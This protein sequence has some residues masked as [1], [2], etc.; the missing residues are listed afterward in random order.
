MAPWTAS[1]AS[2]PC[3]ATEWQV[4]VFWRRAHSRFRPFTL[5]T[6]AGAARS[7]KH[8]Q[9]RSPARAQTSSTELKW[10]ATLL[11][12]CW[13]PQA[14]RGVA[15]LPPLPLLGVLESGQGRHG[16]S[17]ACLGARG[18]ASPPAH[19]LPHNSPAAAAPPPAGAGAAIPADHP[20][21]AGP[22]PSSP[23]CLGPRVA[24]PRSEE[25]SRCCLHTSGS[26][27]S[28]DAAAAPIAG[29]GIQR[30]PPATDVQAAIRKFDAALPLAGEKGLLLT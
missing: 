19:T 10:H 21:V 26:L 18:M 4:P 2:S 6:Q 5:P 24:T 3:M 22:C 20:P 17:L 30:Q 11:C 9:D 15:A 12:A 29:P 28:L 14:S 8:L 27:G 13:C 7:K 16:M 1:W 23:R 25:R